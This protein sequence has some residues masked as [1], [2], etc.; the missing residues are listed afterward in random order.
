[1]SKSPFKLKKAFLI[2]SPNYNLP[3]NQ[4]SCVICRNNLNC[5]SLCFQNSDKES[6]IVKGNCNHA[7]HRECIEPWVKNNPR[8]PICN[9]NWIEVVN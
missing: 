6:E 5:T 4:K 2:S 3:F 1:M 8:C 7:F 9:K